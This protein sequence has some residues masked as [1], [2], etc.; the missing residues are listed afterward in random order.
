MKGQ[1]MPMDRNNAHE[2]AARVLHGTWLHLR[3]TEPDPLTLRGAVYA[4]RHLSG[5]PLER[6]ADRCSVSPATYSNWELR[7]KPFNAVQV[8]Q[9]ENIAV[10]FGYPAIAEFLRMEHLRILYW[11]KRR[12]KNHTRDENMDYAKT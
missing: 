11:G 4:I 10:E 5:V 9:L 6:I 3:P 8:K 7:G 12:G 2:F 1:L